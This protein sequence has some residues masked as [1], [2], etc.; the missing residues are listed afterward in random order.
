MRLAGTF[1]VVCTLAC[2]ATLNAADKQFKD[3]VHAIS[4]ALNTRPVHIPLMGL[5]NAAAFV[6][7]PAGTRHMDLAVFENLNEDHDG[8]DIALLIRKKGGSDWKP[9]LH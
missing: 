7:R 8:R 1:A 3:V 9:F 2:S 6:V 5:V 4:A